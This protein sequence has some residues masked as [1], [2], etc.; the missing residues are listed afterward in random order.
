[1]ASCLGD[2][3]MP[4]FHVTVERM[5]VWHEGGGVACGPD[6]NFYKVVVEKKTEEITPRMWFSHLPQIQQFQNHCSEFT[7]VQIEPCV[8]SIHKRMEGTRHRGLRTN[9]IQ[10]EH[11]SES[12]YIWGIYVY[13]NL[14]ISVCL[15]V[16]I[17]DYS[18]LIEAVI[19]SGVQWSDSAIHIHVSFLP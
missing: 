3:F 5:E 13:I 11:L 2:G 19:I 8:D 17:L 10:Y 1:M 4:K 6:S 15:F 12:T 14:L 16:F 18:H 9:C 7:P